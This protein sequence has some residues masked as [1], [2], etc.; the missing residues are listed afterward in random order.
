MDASLPNLYQFGI[1]WYRD[2]NKGIKRNRMEKLIIG[3]SG[4]SRAGKD[5]IAK[6]LKEY[7]D[8]LSFVPVR[9]VP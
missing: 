1:Q 2:Y 3:I 6:K 4:M 8:F 7:L 5:T 9:I